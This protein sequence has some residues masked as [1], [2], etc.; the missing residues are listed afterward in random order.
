ML[1]HFARIKPKRELVNIAI[2][3]LLADVVECSVNS[4][5]ENRPHT[6]FGCPSHALEAWETTMPYSTTYRS[7]S[8]AA[9]STGSC[10]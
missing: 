6:T 1:F 8:D 7:N 5:L 10:P 9:H 3:M 4:A 2:S